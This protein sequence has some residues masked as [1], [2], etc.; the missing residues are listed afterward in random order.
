MAAPTYP[1]FGQGIAFPFR[2]DPVTGGVV[3]SAGRSDE[4][5]VGL[6]YLHDRWTM[7][8]HPPVVINHIAESIAHIL[9]VAPGEHDTLPEFGSYLFN[10]I[11]EPNNLPLQF[12]AN[13]YFE[14]STI[15]W[16]KRAQVPPGRGVEWKFEGILTDRGELPVTVKVEFIVQQTEG[17]L[18]APFVNPRQ[19]RTQEYDSAIID[20][21]GHDYESRYL[22]QDV[23]EYDGIQYVRLPRLATPILPAADDQFYKVKLADT[24]LLISWELYHDIRFW[25][26]I[27]RMASEDNATL[28]ASR[29]TMS[30]CGDP[31]PGTILRAPSRTRLLTQLSGAANG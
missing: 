16:E 24:W 2:V 28:G 25:W 1:F 12:E 8:E 13:Y 6:A 10:L 27:A 29:D 11:F 22:G 30:T 23:L 18:V 17:N 4:I 9:L 5:S 21:A 7:R 20:V 15:R 31:V 14:Y 19:A 3:V 26:V